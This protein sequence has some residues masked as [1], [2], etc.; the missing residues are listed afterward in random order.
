MGLNKEEI[1]KILENEPGIRELANIKEENKICKCGHKEKYHHNHHTYD[2]A[3]GHC[4]RCMMCIWD[5]N[6]GCYEFKEREVQ[7]NDNSNNGT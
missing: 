6:K 4:R 3:L 5:V 2:W 7:E 1:K